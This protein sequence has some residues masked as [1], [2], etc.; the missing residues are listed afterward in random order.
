LSI[1]AV[2]GLFILV[3]GQMKTE[4]QPV[5]TSQEECT[6]AIKKITKGIKEDKRVA[7]YDL[8][9]VELQPKPTGEGA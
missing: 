1:F 8:Q 2:V 4:V 5:G 7:G 9:C 3:N 6:D